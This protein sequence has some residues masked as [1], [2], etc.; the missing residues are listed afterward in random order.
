MTP[1]PRLGTIRC[2]K[3]S[4][5]THSALC[6]GTSD[7]MVQLA[8]VCCESYSS[9]TINKWK[10]FYRRTELNQLENHTPWSHA[11]IFKSLGHQ[12]WVYTSLGRSCT[13]A[14]TSLL[15]YQDCGGWRLEATFGGVRAPPPLA[16]TRVVRPT[17][18]LGEK[19][20]I[21]G[22]YEGVVERGG[23]T[24]FSVHTRKE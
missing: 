11:A 15:L 22:K 10:M 14:V 17:D 24:T 23:R 2:P 21:R 1:V 3:E 16:H 12:H 5:A 19:G 8:H 6:A 7:S 13:P 9:S 18:A 4:N 20:P